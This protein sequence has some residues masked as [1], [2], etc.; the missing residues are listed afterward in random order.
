[1]AFP[2]SLGICFF[3]FLFGCLLLVGYS[4]GCWTLDWD[5]GVAQVLV[6]PLSTSCARRLLHPLPA[7]LSVPSVL[8]V[9]YA[10]RIPSSGPAWWPSGWPIQ[11]LA[12]GLASAW[13]NPG[14][15]GQVGSEPADEKAQSR[16]PSSPPISTFHINKSC[17]KIS[18]SIVLQNSCLVSFLVILQKLH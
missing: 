12:C 7:F 18:L 8:L 14:C 17:P 13:P 9:A 11:L 10:S 3:F 4:Q 16:P 5:P 2:L 1:M 6:A 15:S